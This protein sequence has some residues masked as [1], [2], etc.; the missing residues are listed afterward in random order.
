MEDLTRADLLSHFAVIADMIRIGMVR[1]SSYRGWHGRV[2]ILTSENDSTQHAGDR[3]RLEA[4][5]TWGATWRE[6]TTNGAST[7]G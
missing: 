4:A 7:Y 5:P 2:V 3:A 1:A 6:L